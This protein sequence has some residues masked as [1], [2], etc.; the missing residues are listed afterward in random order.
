MRNEV[1]LE[2]IQEEHRARLRA[3]DHFESTERSHRRQEYQSIKTDISPKSYDDKLDWF[4]GRVCE[5]TG[6]W[7]TRDA[8]F[9]KWLDISDISAKVLWLEG[10]PGAG[11]SNCDI[12][13]IV[14]CT[15]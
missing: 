10:I 3:L 1:R 9:A 15:C 14:S 12:F 6:N 5:G 13:G 11:A 8:S 4:H 2:H 7:L